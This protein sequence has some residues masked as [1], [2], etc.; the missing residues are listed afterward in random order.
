[1][2]KVDLE[3]LKDKQKFQ[4][5]MK[6]KTYIFK[7]NQGT[8]VKMCRNCGKQM[9]VGRGAVI[10]ERDVNGTVLKRTRNNDPRAFFHKECRKEGRRLAHKNEKMAK[11]VTS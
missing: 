1:M 5:N 7:L 8:T 11:I 4:N 10:E 2:P 6:S 3:N 9:T